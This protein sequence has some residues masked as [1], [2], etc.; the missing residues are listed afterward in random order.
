MYRKCKRQP[1]TNCGI[2]SCNWKKKTKWILA[3]IS[4]LIASLT[5][6]FSIFGKTIIRKKALVS[7]REQITWRVFIFLGPAFSSILSTA[8]F[9]A[10]GFM[11]S[12]S[13]TLPIARGTDPKLATESCVPERSSQTALIERSLKSRPK[14]LGK[15]SNI[16]LRKIPI[17]FIFLFLYH[18]IFL[19][20]PLQYFNLYSSCHKSISYWV[21]VGKYGGGQYNKLLS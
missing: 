14:E 21:P 3:S 19:N 7:G 17:I 8:F 12:P 15:K 11:I 1:A 2:P 13:T 20:T 6:S 9:T 4:H 5:S 16:F 10:S 18:T